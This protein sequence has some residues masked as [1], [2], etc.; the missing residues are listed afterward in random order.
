[1]RWMEDIITNILPGYYFKE[2]GI[3]MG[4][5]EEIIT[6]ILSGYYFKE[7]P[8]VFDIFVHTI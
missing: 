4:W 1:M 3:G 6:N 8:G 2:F 7:L 5:T